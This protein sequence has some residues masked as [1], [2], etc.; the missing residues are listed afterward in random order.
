TLFNVINP[1]I[2]YS[3]I[4][5]Y[6]YLGYYY[7]KATPYLFVSELESGHYLEIDTITNNSTK[8]KWFDIST[9]YLNNNKL[10]YSDTIEQLDYKLKLAV[11][12]RIDSSDLDVGSFL[13]GGID[14]GL[15][16]SIAAS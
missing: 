10:S 16:T 11:K 5:D 12:R 4:A 6:L 13:S 1:Q 8:I 2:N 3:A 7:R 9:S 14:S 15:V